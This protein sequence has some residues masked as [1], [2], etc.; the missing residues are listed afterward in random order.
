MTPNNI[1]NDPL[2]KWKRYIE[3]DGL[4]DDYARL[5]RDFRVRLQKHHA[6]ETEEPLPFDSSWSEN[7]QY[8]GSG[9][10]AL[11]L[12]PKC[13]KELAFEMSPRQSETGQVIILRTRAI[14]VTRMALDSLR[15]NHRTCI[16]GQS[17]R[18]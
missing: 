13:N 16:V 1:H 8:L 14:P 6:N 9:V 10:F 17:A 7:I 12:G 3:W 4:A 2:A 15:F 5:G 11:R 18:A